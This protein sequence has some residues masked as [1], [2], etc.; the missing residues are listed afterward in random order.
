MS[1]INLRSQ[2]T[3][4]LTKGAFRVSLFFRIQSNIEQFFETPC[5]VTY[6]AVRKTKQH[7]LPQLKLGSTTI[8]ASGPPAFLYYA[9]NIKKHICSSVSDHIDNSC[10]QKIKN[11]LRKL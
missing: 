2:K 4:D 10:I 6:F 9:L 5:G 3:G 7:E 8:Y 11:Q 1:K